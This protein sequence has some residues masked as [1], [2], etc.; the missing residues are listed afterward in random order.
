M[1]CKNNTAPFSFHP[2][3]DRYLFDRPGGH[4]FESL[5]QSYVRWKF[6]LP[7][8]LGLKLFQP[9][10]HPTCQVGCPRREWTEASILVLTCHPQG[11]RKPKKAFTNFLRAFSSTIAPF[12]CVERKSSFKTSM[13]SKTFKGNFYRKIL[14]SQNQHHSK[15]NTLSQSY[16]NALWTSISASFVCARNLGSGKTHLL[17]VMNHLEQQQLLPKTG[18][19]GFVGE[20]DGPLFEKIA[21]LF[22]RAV[23]GTEWRR[24][25]NTLLL[26]IHFLLQERPVAFYG[27]GGPGFSP[28]LRKLPRHAAIC[29]AKADL[30]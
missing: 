20:N 16:C 13:W 29:P 26:N 8:H 19:W 15:K 1:H 4:E 21:L 14:L 11:E 12:E 24:R 22:R 2:K 27:I 9:P 10:L 23:Q 6:R 5:L 18:G 28:I 30:A 17:N 3:K 25:A 7:L